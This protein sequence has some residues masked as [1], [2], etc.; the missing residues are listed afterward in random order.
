MADRWSTLRDVAA[1]GD[2]PQA[3]YWRWVDYL[4]QP[5]NADEYR[6]GSQRY[7]VWED[8]SDRWIVEAVSVASSATPHRT[9]Q[10]KESAVA[11]LTAEGCVYH[12]TWPVYERAPIPPRTAPW[13]GLLGVALVLVLLGAMVA[14][15]IV[16]IRIVSEKGPIP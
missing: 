16:V 3:V 7:I 14:G 11:A 2:S 10:S 13:T 4:T 6:V 9:F 8:Q 1:S 5:I 15:M 12:H